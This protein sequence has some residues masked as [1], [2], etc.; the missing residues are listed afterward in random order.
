VGVIDEIKQRVDIVEVVSWYVPGLKKA[1]RSFKASCPFHAE[2]T[3]SFF[4]FPERQSW[5]CFGA[6][7]T[8]GDAF[9]FVMRKEGVDFGEALRILAQRAGVSL[10]PLQPSGSQ[11][12]EQRLKEINEAAAEY[13]H[14]LLLSQAG[15]PVQRYLTQR[16]VAEKTIED[17]Q[18]GFS[19]D[20]WEALR[21]ELTRKGYREDELLAAGLLVQ[22]EQE[23]ERAYDRFRNRLMFPI[24]SADG[25]VVGFG[26][27]ALDDSLPK[28]LNSPQ[29]PVFDKSSTL[30]GIDRAKSAIRKQNLAIVVEGYMDVIMAHQYGFNNVVASL[31][32]ALT[33]KQVGIV[34]KL[35]KNLTLALDADVAGEMA[36]LRG[37]E[38][39][40]QTF[41]QP[42]SA[43][44]WTDVKYEN[45]YDADWKVVILPPGKDPD[46]I[47][48][49]SAE[50]WQHLV[51]QAAPVI[52]YVFSTVASKLDLTDL[53]GKSS[54]VDQLLPVVKEIRDP[55]SQAHY[56][57]KLS[58]LVGVDE[59]E[60]ASALR[61]LK[62][63]ARLRQKRELEQPSILISSLLLTDPLAEY[64]LS[65]LIR[66]PHLRSLHSGLSP[67]FFHHSEAR[68]LFLAWRDSTDLDAMRS[69]LDG[70]L[71]EYLEAL[72]GRPLPP[73]TEKEQEEALG[74][75]VLR[76]RERWLKDLKA[77]EEALI[78]DLQ[79]EGSTAELEELQQLGV[80]LN[81]QLCELFLHGKERKTKEQRYRE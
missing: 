55:V 29:T 34:K 3:P 20:S 45:P 66:H 43:S 5:H 81:T 30:Y 78:S 13:Y 61:R 23:K 2:K 42:M 65:L 57:Q 15:Q 58:R 67:D 22:K 71:Q 19:L 74:D 46:D 75:C 7:A 14:Y 17:F 50:Q 68:Q 60:L 52:E 16:G 37:Q 64:C 76:L 51:T 6:C 62:G 31:G 25:R 24:R 1:G 69:G 11:R 41:G 47:I 21:D 80:K 77:K 63:S 48:R 36:M 54:A 9:S 40:S 10:A 73:M 56:L 44:G 53:K 70:S 38:V 12:E 27:R 39:I 4:V 79:A 8:G 28:Y 26:A 32:T 72:V 18:L 33:E 59:R 49:E 35:T